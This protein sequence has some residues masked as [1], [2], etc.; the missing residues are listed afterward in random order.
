MVFGRET[1]LP[2]DTL[3]EKPNEITPCAADYTQ[4]LQSSLRFVHAAAGRHLGD[5]LRAQKQY[6]DR[7]I[8]KRTFEVGELVLWLRPHRAKLQKFRTG[9]WLL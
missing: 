5:K 9:E 8:N 2:L 6:F 7:R 3:Y 1:A 4:W